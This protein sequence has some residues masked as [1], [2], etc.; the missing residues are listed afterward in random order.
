ML[1][2]E[3]GAARV[4]VV[5][6]NGNPIRYFGAETR[7]HAG[8]SRFRLVSSGTPLDLA[9]DGAGQIYVLYFAGGGAD[10][11]DYRVDVYTPSGP[12]STPTARA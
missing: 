1:V 8:H 7:R 10:P 5:D 12:C 3:A 4:A 6:L 9:V 2:L 11:A